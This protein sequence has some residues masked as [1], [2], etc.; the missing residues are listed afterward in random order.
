MEH[1]NRHTFSRAF[2]G[3]PD[4][5]PVLMIVNISALDRINQQR[6]CNS[7]DTRLAGRFFELYKTDDNCRTVLLLLIFFV[8]SLHSFC[9]LFLVA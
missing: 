1:R 8:I 6:K 2:P 5:C 3:K 4:P 9:W 7:L